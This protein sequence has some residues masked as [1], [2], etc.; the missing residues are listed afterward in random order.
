MRF[1]IVFLLGCS[2]V[3]DD[4]PPP[5][6]EPKLAASCTTNAECPTTYSCFST[7]GCIKEC[8]SAGVGE[9]HG[10][11]ANGFCYTADASVKGYCALLCETDADCTKVNK[12]LL[13]KQRSATEASGKKV[14]V[15]ATG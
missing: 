11:P 10:C 8:P 6:V 1:A 12:E 5:K 2:G 15:T 9:A 4:P 14:C 7:V 13:C 3:A